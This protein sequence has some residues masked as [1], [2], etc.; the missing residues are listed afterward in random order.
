MFECCDTQSEDATTLTQFGQ[1]SYD[2]DHPMTH[3]IVVVIL[4]T[5]SLQELDVHIKIKD[6]KI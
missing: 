6:V 1:A 2:Q 4:N 3:V 5:K